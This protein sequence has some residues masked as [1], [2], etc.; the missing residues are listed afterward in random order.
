[1]QMTDLEIV[2]NY[3]SAKDPKKQI[4]I[5]AQ[6]NVCNKETIRKILIK[7]GV[8][9]SELPSKRGPKPKQQVVVETEEPSVDTEDT[10]PEMEHSDIENGA[11]VDLGIIEPLR[12]S[13]YRTME[14]ILNTEI[15]NDREAKRVERYKLIPEVV[16]TVCM[17]EIK[18]LNEE[19]ARLNEKTMQLEKQHDILVDYLN[20]E[21]V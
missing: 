21:E 1:M 2:A 14:D 12:L 20:G 9:E 8:P 6:L 16:K 10:M 13:E 15:Q 18:K 4:E 17:E 5:L 11:E 3:K 7:N 19:I